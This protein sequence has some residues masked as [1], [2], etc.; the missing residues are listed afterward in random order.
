MD[1][2]ICQQLLDHIKE[3]VTENIYSRLNIVG[4]KNTLVYMRLT[5]R[6]ASE[7]TVFITADHAHLSDWDSTRHLF[8]EGNQDK[9]IENMFVLAIMYADTLEG[10]DEIHMSI[11]E[12]Y[13]AIPS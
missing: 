6:K 12:L 5:R 13:N 8:G 3:K 4:E 9:E 11:D 2:E 10:K 7:P 1:K